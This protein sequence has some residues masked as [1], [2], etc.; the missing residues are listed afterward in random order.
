[1]WVSTSM[2]ELS[3]RSGCTLVKLGVECREFGK[4]VAGVHPT[5]KGQAY[6]AQKIIEIVEETTI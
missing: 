5:T 3:Q 1:M 6:I 4:Y 2:E